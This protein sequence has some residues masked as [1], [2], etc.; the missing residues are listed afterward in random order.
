MS[1]VG[2][3]M[4]GGG[5]VGPGERNERSCSSFY[6]GASARHRLRCLE[7]RVGR[8]A[9]SHWRGVCQAKQTEKGG[10]D[11]DDDEGSSSNSLA[12]RES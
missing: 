10:T 3:T 1:S 2:V 5:K 7:F 12:S 6:M 9:G 11:I 4:C 8:E